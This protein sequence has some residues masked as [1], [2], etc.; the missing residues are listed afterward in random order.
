MIFEP[1]LSDL[2]VNESQGWQDAATGT[3]PQFLDRYT[4]HDSTWLGLF[5]VPNWEAVLVL[6]WD[7]FWANHQQPR[8][9]WHGEP[10]NSCYLL[11]SLERLWRMEADNVGDAGMSEIVG[12]A[13]SALI[14]AGQKPALIERFF[15]RVKEP[16]EKMVFDSPLYHT[17]FDHVFNRGWELWHGGK[18][19]FLCFTESGERLTIPEIE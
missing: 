6:Q 13:T 4:L 14:D 18:T 10:V 3:L 2:I 15:H 19:R 16:A 8:I 5:A 17:A 11:I 12:G 1:W 7:S 9:V